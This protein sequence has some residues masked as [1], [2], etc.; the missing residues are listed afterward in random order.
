M[1]ELPRRDLSAAERRWLLDLVRTT[2]AA[3]L[4]GEP[5]PDLAPEPGPLTEPRGAFVTL[6]RDN[7]LRGCIGHVIGTDP[8]WRSV[9]VNAVNA[10]FRDPR[11]PQVTEDELP[12]LNVE[13]S[14]LSP[15]WMIDSPDQIEIGRDGLIVERGQRRGLLLPQVAERYGWSPTEFLDHTCLKAGLEPG[16]WRS[17]DARIAGFSAEVFSELDTD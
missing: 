13:V 6:T 4:A 8:L 17:S 2:I 1:V 7:V 3:R 14:A 15:L 5:D 10:A 11:F 12:G 16:C 9:R